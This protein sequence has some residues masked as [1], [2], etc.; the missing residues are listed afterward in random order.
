MNFQI[1]TTKDFDESFN[2]FGYEELTKKVLLK[3]C[4]KKE[5][6][7][8]GEITLIDAEVGKRVFFKNK[9]DQNFT[10]RY[11]LTEDDD[12]VW[13]ACYTLFIDIEDSDGS[14][15]GE[16]ISQGVATVHYPN[17]CIQDSL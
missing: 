11:F 1:I 2:V 10:I 7:L 15:H 8:D 13:K 9:N 16:E 17:N 3:C 5:Y 14:G 6:G 4:N 12:E